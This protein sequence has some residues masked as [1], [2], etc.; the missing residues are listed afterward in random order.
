MSIKSH[1]QNSCELNSVIDSLIIIFENNH[2][3]IAQVKENYIKG[4]KAKHTSPNLFGANEIHS[5][6]GQVN[7][8]QICFSKN[9]VDLFTK[10]VPT[11]S[12]EKLVYGIGMRD[13]LKRTY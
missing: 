1:I 4:K 8:R 11:S 2:A 6:I 9:L 12:F 3:C 10:S 13:T 5:S 7:I